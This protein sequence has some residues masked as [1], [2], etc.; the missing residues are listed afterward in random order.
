MMR[1][2]PYDEI[3]Y[4]KIPFRFILFIVVLF[5]LVSVA[6]LVM[7]A[8]Q[9]YGRPIGGEELPDWFFLA[10]AIYMAGMAVFIANFREMNINLTYQS[11]TIT[12]GWVKKV[13]LWVD[14]EGYYH[15]KGASLS[16]GGIHFSIGKKGRLR[17]SYTVLGK[18]RIVLNLRAGKFKDFEFS[19]GNPDEVM[20]ILKK[21]TG[22]EESRKF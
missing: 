12:Y 1:N 13:I 21:Q 20:S 18:P 3:Y 17:M 16:N 11:L 22:K 9:I 10:F 19:T 6:F 5:G 4:E 15:D 14:I 7:F 2:K 8:C